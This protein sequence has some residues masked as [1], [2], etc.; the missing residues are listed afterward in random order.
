MNIVGGNILPNGEGLGSEVRQLRRKLTIFNQLIHQFLYTTFRTRQHQTQRKTPQLTTVY[1]PTSSTMA[2]SSQTQLRSLYRRFLRELPARSPSLLA[3]PS[4]IQHTIRSDFA[5]ASPST[6]TASLDHQIRSKSTAARLQEGEQ[7]LQYVKNQRVYVTLLE[8][9]NP[10][11]NMAEEDR[12]RMTARRVG[13]EMPIEM[14][15]GN[16]PKGDQ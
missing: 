2:T 10:G 9:Y 13:M 15:K 8:R 14:M 11:M 16:K 4:P 7:L 1:A 5:T 6:A 3:N 12:T